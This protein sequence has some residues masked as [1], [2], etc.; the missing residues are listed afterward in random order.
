M[1]EF[2]F[3]GHK[4]SYQPTASCISISTKYLLR[5]DAVGSVCFHPLEARILSVAGS[6]HW[7]E[8]VADEGSAS[9]GSD[10]EDND[11]DDPDGRRQR[12]TPN[13]VS[14]DSSVVLWDCRSTV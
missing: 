10:E 12:R 9:D 8:D 4:G 6:R 2:R 1:P 14:F 7:P 13:V 3:V 5:L 11:R